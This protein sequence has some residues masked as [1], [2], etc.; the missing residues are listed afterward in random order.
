MSGQPG[1]DNRGPSEV[2]V[3]LRAGSVIA[4]ELIEVDSLSPIPKEDTWPLW[5]ILTLPAS[6][7]IIASIAGVGVVIELG[8]KLLPSDLVIEEFYMHVSLVILSSIMSRCI[9]CVFTFCV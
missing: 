3:S 5:N 2:E 7:S 8:F 6:L 9:F 1:G 4:M